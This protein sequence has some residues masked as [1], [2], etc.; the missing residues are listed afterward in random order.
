M[1]RIKRKE[2]SL[3]NTLINIVATLLDYSLASWF[4]IRLWFGMY[5]PNTRLAMIKPLMRIKKW[6]TS[7]D[8]TCPVTSTRKHAQWQ[9]QNYQW[10]DSWIEH[11]PDLRGLKMYYGAGPWRNQVMQLPCIW[12]NWSNAMLFSPLEKAKAGMKIY[13]TYK[14]KS[15]LMSLYSDSRRVMHKTVKALMRSPRWPVRPLQSDLPYD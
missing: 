15:I 1:S 12:P 14:E 9:A 5:Q 8:L 11:E 13:I 2:K 7:F 6:S 10:I 3:R 4:S